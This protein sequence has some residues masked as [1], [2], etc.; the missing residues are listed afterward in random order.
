MWLIGIV[1]VARAGF[2]VGAVVGG[3]S[4]R[5]TCCRS[6]R[7]PSAGSSSDIGQYW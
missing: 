1:G 2:A 7:G 4:P 3:E 5:T 6:I